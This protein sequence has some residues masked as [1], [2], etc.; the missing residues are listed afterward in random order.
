MIRSNL[1]TRP[2]YNSRA[3]TL[4]L[5]IAALA[6]AA[7]TAFNV[8]RLLQYSGSNTELATHADQ[9]ETS[10]DDMRHRAAA[11][12][13]SVDPRQIETASHD[14]RQANDL[15]D[16]RTLSWTELFNRFETTLPGDV[17]ITAV[18]PEIDEKGQITLDLTVLGRS[19]DDVDQ[20]MERLDATNAFRDVRSNRER[21]N[22][23][24]QIESQLVMV[25]VPLPTTPAKESR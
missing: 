17:R 8:T 19:V 9:D 7:M 12:R 21:K 6:I 15:I 3:V 4:W 13:G 24:G 25:Y 14:A 16:R 2:F 20:F 10:A 11:L 22:E 23:D 1:S 18:H 5:A